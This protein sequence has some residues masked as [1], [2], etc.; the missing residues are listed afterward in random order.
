MSDSLISIRSVLAKAVRLTPALMLTAFAGGAHAAPS[1]VASIQPIHSLAAQV[2]EGVASPALLVP[3][4][5]SPH[6][7][8]L[9][10]AQ[11]E[12][13]KNAD[14]V[15]VVG[16]GLEVHVLPMAQKLVAADHI[17]RLDQAEGLTL[18]SVRAD[19]P[20]WNQELE[21]EHAHHDHEHDHDHAHH[22][23]AIDPHL[24]LDAQNGIA[25]LSLIAERLASIDPANA[26]TYRA[27]AA[28]RIKRL[29][30]LDAEIEAQL[31]PLQS[32]RS[33]VIPVLP[34]HDAYQYFE[35]RYGLAGNGFINQ[36][37]EMNLG[38]KSAGKLLDM[39]TERKINCIFAEPQFNR[40]LV[41]KMAA[42]SGAKVKIIAPDGGALDSGPEAYEQ[43]LRGVADA[44][45]DCAGKAD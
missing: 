23:E 7:F 38:A 21:G 27:N 4:S 34:Y 16:H 22:D 5:Q 42:R 26:D 45:A 12:T 35:A 39:S 33:N 30:K 19:N 18:H 17:L 1:V 41:D 28:A 15:V 25:V 24:W 8:A 43:L 36:R 32:P 10:P 14:L 2:M 31:A 37:P 13:L 3:P 9:T 6:S 29:E 40:R 11:A 20:L 44:F